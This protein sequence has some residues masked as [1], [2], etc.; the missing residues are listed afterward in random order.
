M[1][2]AFLRK[3]VDPRFTPFDW[4]KAM[5]KLL[6]ALFVLLSAAIYLRALLLP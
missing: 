1:A 3:D 2:Y 4:V 5:A 6:L